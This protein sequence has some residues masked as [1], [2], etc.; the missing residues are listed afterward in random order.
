MYGILIYQKPSELVKKFGDVMPKAKNVIGNK[1]ILKCQKPS[2]H[3]NK[4]RDLSTRTTNTRRKFVVHFRKGAEIEVRSDEE[5]YQGAWY[6]AIVV[7]SL[8]NGKYL[9]EY[10]TLKTDDLSEQL[11]EEADASDI[12]PYPPDIN[13]VHRFALRER[14]DAW[15]N[16]GWWVG[17]VSSVLHGF[18]YRVYFWPTK[19]ELEFEHC[20]LRPHQEWIDGRW[21][22]ASLV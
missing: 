14:V 5:G 1:L 9:V 10:L 8:Q 13:H 6:S 11:R 4:P 22:L 2:E 19:E 7:D 3:A 20:D 16:D 15:Y 17:Q 12:R 21:V 18:M